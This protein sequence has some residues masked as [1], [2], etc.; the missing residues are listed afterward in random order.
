[1][2]STGRKGIILVDKQL[3]IMFFSPL[4]SDS[5][6]IN[7]CLNILRKNATNETRPRRQKL[8]ESEYREQ[9]SSCTM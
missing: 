3:L 4:T 6:R 2:C 9:N 7:Y 1:M 5:K 8:S